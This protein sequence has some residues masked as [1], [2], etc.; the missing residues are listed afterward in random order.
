MTTAL[1]IALEGALDI[2]NHR[3]TEKLKYQTESHHILNT[4]KAEGAA[5]ELMELKSLI[6]SELDKINPV[7]PKQEELPLDDEVLIYK[8]KSYQCILK[9][10]HNKI[11]KRGRHY[12]VTNS[13][14]TVTQSCGDIDTALYWAAKY[15]IEPK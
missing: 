15:P 1:T 6:L 4:A 13:N 14:N 3:L 11:W 12:L 10:P 8:D 9:N 7:N 2:V 5:N